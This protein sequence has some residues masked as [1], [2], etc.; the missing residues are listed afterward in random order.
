MSESESTASGAS[1]PDD[2]AATFQYKPATSL[3]SN[4]NALVH[5]ELSRDYDQISHALSNIHSLYGG[6]VISLTSYPYTV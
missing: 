6:A 5:Y 1:V 3:A 4:N 2:K